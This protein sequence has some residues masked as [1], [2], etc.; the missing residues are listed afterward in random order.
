MQ[1][2]RCKY[3]NSKEDRYEEY[4]KTT[5]NNAYCLCTLLQYYDGRN[6]NLEQNGELVIYI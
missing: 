2:N 1:E 5:D 6:L 4:N 3:T